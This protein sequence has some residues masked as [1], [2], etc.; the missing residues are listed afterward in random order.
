MSIQYFPEKF[1]CNLEYYESETFSGFSLYCI[2]GSE[3]DF[4]FPFPYE[5]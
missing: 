2:F 4:R 5:K 1:R 3:T